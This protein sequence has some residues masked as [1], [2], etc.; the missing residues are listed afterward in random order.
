MALLLAAWPAWP[1]PAANPYV[2]D[3]DRAPYRLGI[4]AAQRSAGAGASSPP[5]PSAPPSSA[6]RLQRESEI[7]AL[8]LRESEYEYRMRELARERDAWRAHAQRLESEL[9]AGRTPFP[10]LMALPPLR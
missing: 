4:P 8:R 10:P 3:V 1:Q 7:A 5:T 6:T 2:L 9:Q